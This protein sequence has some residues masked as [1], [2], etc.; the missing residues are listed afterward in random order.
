[1]AR[2]DPNQP[3]YD[4]RVLPK[5]QQLRAAMPAALRA[6][7]EAYCTATGENPDDVVH[8]AVVLDLDAAEG[9]VMDERELGFFDATERSA[10]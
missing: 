7:L 6:K 3:I 2:S 5:M 9:A 10:S 4:P 1:M 8:D